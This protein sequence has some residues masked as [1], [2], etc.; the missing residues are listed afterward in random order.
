MTPTPVR[1]ITLNLPA[2]RG[3]A[4]SPGLTVEEAVA[5]RDALEGMPG[6]ARAPVEPPARRLAERAPRTRADTDL[7][8]VMAEN[9]AYERDGEARRAEPRRPPEPRRP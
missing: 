4:F 8:L 6:P 5:I 7:D 1:M 3:Y 9:R 2:W